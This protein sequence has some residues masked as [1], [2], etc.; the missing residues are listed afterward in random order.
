MLDQIRVDILQY[1]FVRFK[2]DEVKDLDWMYGTLYSVII[3][4]LQKFSNPELT[5]TEINSGK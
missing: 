5:I 2:L 1:F 3:L 4:T